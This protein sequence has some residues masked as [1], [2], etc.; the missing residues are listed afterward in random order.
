MYVWYTQAHRCLRRLEEGVTTPGTGV[1]VVGSCPMWVPGDEP[2]SL[3]NDLG[4]SGRPI[5]AFKNHLSSLLREM[6]AAEE[7]SVKTELEYQHTAFQ[8]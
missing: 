6:Q 4:S 1:I 8:S 5:N 3:G 2:K 7:K